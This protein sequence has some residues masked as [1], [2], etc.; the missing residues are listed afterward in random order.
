LGTGLPEKKFTNSIGQKKEADQERSTDCLAKL[1]V[2]LQTY[3][4]RPINLQNARDQGV[5][6]YPKN[7]FAALPVKSIKS[8]SPETQA[9]PD[10]PASKNRNET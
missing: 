4:M 1:F 6:S 7:V 8:R 10:F 9:Q 2:I 3:K 5:S